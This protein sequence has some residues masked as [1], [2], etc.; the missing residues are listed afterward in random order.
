LGGPLRILN[1]MRLF[2]LLLLA[3]FLYSPP[4]VGDDG[5]MTYTL[6]PAVQK[7]QG[8]PQVNIKAGSDYRKLELI[9]DRSDGESVTLSTGSV[10]I[11]KVKSFDLKQPEGELRWNCEAR[12]WYGTGEGEFYDLPMSFSAFLGGGL[13]M[14]IPR[15]EIDRQARMLVAKADRTV[16]SAHVTVIGE[17]GPVFDQDVE[18]SENEPGDEILIQWEGPEEVL[19]LDVTLHDK[20]GFYAFENI[21]PWSLEIPHDDVNFS[22]GSHAIEDSEMK[23]VDTAWKDHIHDKVAAY[24]KYVEVRLYIGGY[25]DTVGDR[26]DNQALST[27]RA[28]AIAGAFRNKGFTGPI[29][30]Q[31]FGEDGLAIAT[32]DSVD[33]ISNRRAVYILASRPPAP[34]S[35]LPRANW[36]AL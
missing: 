2:A 18:V 12:G 17:E 28:K 6:K 36:K 20:W 33:E 8:Y 35:A 22:S 31:G 29:Y 13:A 34:S 1:E 10:G 30:Y 23:K 14:E 11:G 32:E 16:V 15:A 27:R 25:T 5:L 19:R 4:A 21:F 7:G 9:C 26:G 3:V 24:S